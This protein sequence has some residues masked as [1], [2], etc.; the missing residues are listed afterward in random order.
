MHTCNL[1]MDLYILP[2]WKCCIFLFLI[3]S[4]P[5]KA[6]GKYFSK[7]PSYRS[8]K[9]H[10]SF[11]FFYFYIQRNH[12]TK[13]PCQCVLKPWKDPAEYLAFALAITFLM[14]DLNNK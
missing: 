2:V 3:P 14:F 9:T 8:F 11:Q 5:Q 10:L 13:D 12:H 7:H 6:E 4:S 1:C